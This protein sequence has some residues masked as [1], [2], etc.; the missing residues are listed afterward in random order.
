MS[1]WRFSEQKPHMS[2]SDIASQLIEWFVPDIYAQS[3]GRRRKRIYRSFLDLD[4]TR[5]YPQSCP[6]PTIEVS[7]SSCINPT[8]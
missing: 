8:N 7:S 2:S 5:P 1:G 4:V 3:R 6:G